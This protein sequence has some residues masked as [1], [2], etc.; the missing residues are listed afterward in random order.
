MEIKNNMADNMDY[1]RIFIAT[2]FENDAENLVKPLLYLDEE[3]ALSLRKVLPEKIHLTW[4]FLGDF[5]ASKTKELIE[6]VDESA[7]LIEQTS[8]NMTALEIWP[9]RKRPRQIV[10]TSNERSSTINS[11]YNTLEDGLFKLD[12]AKESRKFNP[13]ITLARFKK[14]TKCNRPILQLLENFIPQSLYINNVNIVQSTLS[15]KGS[16]YKILYNIP[17]K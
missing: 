4:K 11:F 16:D 8:L 17:I 12:I 7:K 10:I 13:H 15:S 9:N 2:F 1:L 5:S 3:T 6:K 14:N